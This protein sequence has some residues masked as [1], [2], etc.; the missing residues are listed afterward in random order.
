MTHRHKLA[1]AFVR[2]KK[3]L[4]GY[5][6]DG[7]GL[8]L[9]VS[10]GGSR[11][12][13]LRFTL[14]KKTRE[15]GLGSTDDFG[16]AQARERAQDARRLIANNI[17]P[18]DK[19]DAERKLLAE[20]RN[21]VA[22]QR[23][24]EAVRQVSF[25]QVAEAYITDH[26]SD[27]KN[28]K[29]AS[30]WTNTLTT[31]IF[32]TLGAKSIGDISNLDIADALKPIWQTKAETA[33]RILYRIKLVLQSAA[34]KEL[35]DPVEANFY[36]LIE[37]ILGKNKR[38]RQVEHHAACPYSIV[39]AVLK[40]IREGPSSAVVKLAFEFT[41]L[42]AARSGETR[43]ATR[44][45]FD[46]ARAVWKIPA[47]RMKAGR[48]HSV[49]LSVD[50]EQIVQ[51]ALELQLS[52]DAETS[53]FL[54]PNTKGGALSDMV[55]TQMLRRAGFEYTMH[56]FRS[57]FHVWASEQTQHEHEM[58]EFALA[59]RVGTQTV[60]SYMR[61]DMLEKRRQLMLDWAKHV[62]ATSDASLPTLT[63][64]PRKSAQK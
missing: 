46:Q 50:A 34:A 15:M 49:P 45:E 18:I 26:T 16:L 11:S 21:E 13:V 58:I 43:G 41:V 29:H 14:D 8:Y 39:G 36:E 40:T 2:S 28:A 54:F 5:H 59:H 19:R 42:T 47:K 63:V 55:F 17:D 20:H 24:I 57:T 7:H 1:D 33:T 62:E 61:T 30:Q 27:W 22:R 9:Q 35:R 44:A 37:G 51:A 25:K 31:Y 48:E 38:A 6:L 64:K 32:P 3:V 12:W 52:G 53:P 60:R 56:G 23:K 4:P 10:K